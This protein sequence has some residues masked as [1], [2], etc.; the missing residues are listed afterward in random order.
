[1]ALLSQLF[2]ILSLRAGPQVLPASPVLLIA[3]VL[4]D[5]LLSVAILSTGVRTGQA[6][7]MVAASIGLGL[8]FSFVALY[9]R[10][11]TNRFL[12]TAT[13]LFG[14]DILITLVA[15]PL[16]LLVVR[17]LGPDSEGILSPN[18]AFGLLVVSAWMLAVV[19]GIFRHALNLPWLA[20]LPVAL[21]YVIVTASISL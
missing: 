12:Q 17:Q 15:M 2:A 5:L 10:S 11:L 6:L 16:S 9:L 4:I 18:L 3:I 19:G 13:A 20:A 8:V 1:L 7:L 21:A 14:A